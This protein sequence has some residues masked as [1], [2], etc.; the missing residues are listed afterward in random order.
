MRDKK[1]LT[2]GKRV[3]RE[4]EKTE[5]RSKSESKHKNSVV[6]EKTYLI[7]SKEIL[8]VLIREFYPHLNKWRS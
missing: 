6:S 4:V 8:L 1:G 2:G 5:P 7:L 3:E